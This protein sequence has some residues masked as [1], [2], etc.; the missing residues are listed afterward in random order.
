MSSRSISILSCILLALWMGTESCLAGSLSAD[1]DAQLET[2]QKRNHLPALAAAAIVDGKIVESAATGFRQWG[3]EDA[4]TIDDQWHIGSCTK[5]MTA[6]LAAMLVEKGVIRW[7]STVADVFPEWRRTMDRGWYEVTLY[8]LLTH[9]G[10]APAHPPDPVW[11]RA[12]QQI[13]TPLEQ[14]KEFVEKLLADPPEGPPREK[15]IYSN[16]G[17][18]IAGAMLERR[19]RRSW[20]EMMRT[21]LFIPLKMTSA[22]F[23]PPGAPGAADRKNASDEPW[24][25]AGTVRHPEPVP[26]T[27]SADNP[28]A[29][30]P[31]STV[32]CSIIDLAKYGAFHA[33]MGATAPG[34]LR[35][36]SF[37]LL[38]RRAPG[39][40]YALGWCVDSR[41]W[42]GGDVLYH[43]GSNTLWYCAL[44]VAP[45]KNAA[46]VA[47]TNCAS[48]LA[49]DACD[50]AVKALISRV[51]D[52]N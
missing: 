36:E 6:T 26:P 43:T 10:G 33:S 27:P 20:E 4:V 45:G 17:Y 23:G 52:D 32:H 15:F 29:I 47:A 19:T 25:H 3:E 5:S 12:W 30:G 13:G 51:I 44:W 49:D 38:H 34:L 18:A 50:Q 41:D 31:A 46:F 37:K 16:Q 40:D 7:D 14:R 24:G 22:G 11:L 48:D 42:A 1:F 9:R 39:E 21:M 28:P 2:I 8:D 35:K